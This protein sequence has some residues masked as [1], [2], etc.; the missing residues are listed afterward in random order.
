MSASFLAQSSDRI[1]AISAASVKVIRATTDEQAAT[2]MLTMVLGAFGVQI[3][4]ETLQSALVEADQ[5]YSLGALRERIESVLAVY[6][7]AAAREGVVLPD[8]PALLSTS[9]PPSTGLYL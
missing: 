4:T 9:K 2:E 6:R 3:I 5:V 7:E 8:M 1:P